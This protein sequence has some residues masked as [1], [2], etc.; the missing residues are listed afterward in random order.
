MSP[1]RAIL[2]YSLFAIV[3]GLV[4]IYASVLYIEPESVP[5]S[6][7]NDSRIGQ[8]IKTEGLVRSA[9]LSN[10]STLFIRL[11]DQECEIDVVLFKAGNAN[12]NPGDLVQVVGEVSKYEGKLEIIAR[13]IKPL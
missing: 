12:A 7:V 10:T 4:G 8:V 13:K 1:E 11:E 2:K 3:I 6:S 9:R 5:L